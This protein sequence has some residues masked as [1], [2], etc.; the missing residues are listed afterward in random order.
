M[1][2]WD[3]SLASDVVWKVRMYCRESPMWFG[4]FGGYRIW[5][6]T[7]RLRSRESHVWTQNACA[8]GSP[9]LLPV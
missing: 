8:L 5:G 4:V 7:E 3:L 6:A 9:D 2:P 1:A